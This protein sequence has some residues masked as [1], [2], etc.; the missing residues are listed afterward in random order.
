MFP[1]GDPLP[2][3]GATANDAS[4]TV[5]ITQAIAVPGVSTVLVTAEDGTTQLTYTIDFHIAGTNATLS[6]L[7][8]DGTTIPGFDPNIFNY[9]YSVATGDPIPVVDATPTDPYAGMEINQATTLPGAATVVV[10]SEDGL[11]VN[12][13]TVNFLYDPG[14]DATLQDLLVAGVTIEGFDPG[15]LNYNYSVIYPDP[16]PYVQGIPNDPLATVVENQCLSIPGDAT[17]EVTAEDGVTQLLYTVSFSYLGYDATLSDLTVDGITIEGFDPQIAYYEYIVP[18]TTDIPIVDGTT[19]DPDASLTV[20]QAQEIPGEA[21][22]LVIAADGVNEM[23]Y[24]VYFY[25]LG[26]DATLSDLTVDGTT[27]GG[28]DPLTFEYEYEVPEGQPVPVLDGT[29]NDPMAIMTITQAPSVP[30]EGNIHVLAQ[31]GIAENTY[32]V[33]FVLITGIYERASDNVFVYPNPAFNYIMFS[34]IEGK[35]NVNIINFIGKSLLELTVTANEPVYIDKLKSG[36]YFA[37][38]SKYNGE[39]KTIRFVKR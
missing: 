4:A 36:I 18:N 37:T 39:I 25:V 5:D 19:T 10:T 31:D 23:T 24:S 28:F 33:N 14:T 1:S 11:T 2:V 16:A 30:G 27:I 22:L 17:I 38:I 12:T 35:A 20:T 34:G 3:T 21:T 15:V 9:D 6:D 13:Y 26:S 7:T 32:L 8:V 29:T